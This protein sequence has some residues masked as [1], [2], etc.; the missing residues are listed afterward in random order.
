MN[1]Y[2]LRDRKLLKTVAVM[3]EVEGAVFLNSQ[4]AKALLGGAVAAKGKSRSAAS[5]AG[6]TAHVLIIGGEKGV[7]RLYKVV[8]EGKNASSFACMPLCAFGVHESGLTDV[9]GGNST[10]SSSGGINSVTAQSINS[11]H[12]LQSKNQLLLSTKDSHFFSF[13]LQGSSILADRQFVGS[14]DDVLDI[15]CLPEHKSPSL[16][17]VRARLAVATNSAVGRLMSCGSSECQ[18]LYGHSDIVLAWA[19]SGAGYVSLS[20]CCPRPPP[21]SFA[22]R[23]ACFEAG[24]TPSS[25][26]R[27]K[28]VL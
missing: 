10:S 13:R 25:P 27:S 11:I 4:H 5:D 6:G 7:V 15:S 26:H 23:F 9:L 24:W 14:H 3:D 18:L 8:L 2:E 22:F 16:G 21:A 12:Y 20:A 19:S 1:F 17:V 28:V